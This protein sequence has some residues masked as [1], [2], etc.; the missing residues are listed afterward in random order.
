VCALPGSGFGFQIPNRRLN[1]ELDPQRL[2]GILCVHLYS[3]ANT[4]LPRIW[5]HIRGRYWS[6]KIDDISL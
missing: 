1:M 2:F 4:P 3:L 5:A 6:A